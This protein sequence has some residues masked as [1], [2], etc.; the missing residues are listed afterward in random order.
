MVGAI[1]EIRECARFC[2]YF[3]LI[4]IFLDLLVEAGRSV[5]AAEERPALVLLRRSNN[6]DK[7]SALVS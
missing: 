4:P 2:Y 5:V 7:D 3:Q 6:E 1:S